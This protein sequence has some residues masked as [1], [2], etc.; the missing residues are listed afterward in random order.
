L[1]EI[2]TSDVTES[3]YTIDLKNIMREDVIDTTRVLTQEQALSNA[4]NIKN[5]KFVVKRIL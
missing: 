2:D 5:G 4:Q 1:K 3:A